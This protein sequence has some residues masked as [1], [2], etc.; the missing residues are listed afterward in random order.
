MPNAGSKLSDALV[1]RWCAR[2]TRECV[3]PLRGKDTSAARLSAEAARSLPCVR[4]RTPPEA[5]C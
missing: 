4:D 5:K 1:L 2:V 3:F